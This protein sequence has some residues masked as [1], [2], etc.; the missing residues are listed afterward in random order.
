MNHHIIEKK[1]LTQKSGAETHKRCVCICIGHTANHRLSTDQT[2]FLLKQILTTV[3]AMVS[4]WHFLFSGS[5]YNLFLYVYGRGD[6]ESSLV[7]NAAL[8]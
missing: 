5:K 1:Y 4:I 8:F 6:S 7:W 3:N 2:V